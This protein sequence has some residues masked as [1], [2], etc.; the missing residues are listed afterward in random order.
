MPGRRDEQGT[1]PA[2]NVSSGKNPAGAIPLFP[3]VS[4][5]VS[6]KSRRG[7]QECVRYN[8][9]LRGWMQLAHPDQAQIGEVGFPIGVARSK[10]SEARQMR[11]R[12]ERRPHQS[13]GYKCR[14]QSGAFK[15]KTGFCE[16]R[17]AGEQGFRYAARQF[18]GP[19]MVSVPA[20]GKCHQKS[21]IREAFS[22]EK[23]PYGLR[24]WGKTPPPPPDA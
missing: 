22:C 17:F 4:V 13:L 20:I 23:N 24:G 5:G 11:G 15:M 7:T 2:G 19:A 9:V 12:V 6:G 1:I 18:N 3:M 21:G 16:N 14:D 10:F 8:L